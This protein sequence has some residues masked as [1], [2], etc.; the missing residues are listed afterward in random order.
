MSCHCPVLEECAAQVRFF[1][2]RIV[3]AIIMLIISPDSYIRLTYER[4]QNVPLVHLISGPD[5]DSPDDAQ[6]CVVTTP[7]TGYTEWVSENKPQLSIGWDWH[8]KIHG[9]QISLR[10]VNPARSNIMLLDGES[11]DLGHLQTATLLD[12]MIDRLDWQNT[13]LDFIKEKRV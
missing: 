6:D 7:I 2:S 8:L 4:L 12:Q 11:T 9:N 3:F 1:F 10:R 13:V 5:Q